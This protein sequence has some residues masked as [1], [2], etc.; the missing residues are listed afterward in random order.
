MFWRSNTSGEQ[1][2]YESA[3]PLLSPAELSF[4]QVASAAVGKSALVLAKVR[5]VNVIK[6]RTGL[7]DARWRKLF[8]PL[9]EQHLDFVLIHSDTLETVCVLEFDSSTH[10]NEERQKRNEYV[11]EVC[12]AAGVPYVLVNARGGFDISDLRSKLMFLWQG[13]SDGI[14]SQPVAAVVD[15][16]EDV[17]VAADTAPEPEQA[18]TATDIT[19]TLPVTVP[20][21]DH[22]EADDVDNSDDVDE[23]QKALDSVSDTSS[24]TLMIDEP[25]SV[26]PEPVLAALQPESEPVNDQEVGQK[27]AETEHHEP[28]THETGTDSKGVET[29]S[30]V[31]PDTQ[32]E[33]QPDSRDEPESPVESQVP[34]HSP[35]NQAV[36]AAATQTVQQDA[37]KSVLKAPDCPKGGAALA[38]RQ[39]KSGKLAGQ[40]IWVCGTYP[41]CRYIAPLKAHK[42]IKIQPEVSI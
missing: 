3:G 14:I 32:L 30:P 18:D 17:P 1:S 22:S 8:E 13:D 15:S 40:F 24:E 35:D 5:M 25:V 21:M 26:T 9:A 39:P 2:D 6:P 16:V 10:L 19:A 34:E 41:D 11:Q 4:Y 38:R 36:A 20:V 42:M 12:E 31:A 7:G 37:S 27:E 33:S 23:V 29:Q 28:N